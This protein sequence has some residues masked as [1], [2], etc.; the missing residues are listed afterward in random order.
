MFLE[1]LLWPLFMSFKALNQYVDILFKNLRAYYSRQK[2]IFLVKMKLIK[3]RR[4]NFVLH[5]ENTLREINLQKKILFYAVLISICNYLHCKCDIVTKMTAIYRKISTND[6]KKLGKKKFEI[7]LLLNIP[8]PM[9]F[10]SKS[11]HHFH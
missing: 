6:L 9:E 7:S 1:R 4:S 8:H 3:K 2:N 10:S 11:F 5:S